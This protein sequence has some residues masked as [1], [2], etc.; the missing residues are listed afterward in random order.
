MSIFQQNPFGSSKTRNLYLIP[1]MLGALVLGMYVLSAVF[2]D[3]KNSKL[4]VFPQL[5]FLCATYP[6]SVPHSWH[7]GSILLL[8][9]S[10][11]PVS[12]MSS[13][14]LFANAHIPS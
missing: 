10:R 3:F 6:E 2:S 13:S 7:Q 9:P 11:T 14:L 5:L 8:A 4:M 12:L 1:A